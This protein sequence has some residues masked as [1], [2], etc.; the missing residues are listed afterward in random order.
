MIERLILLAV[1]SLLA[2]PSMAFLKKTASFGG[3]NLPITVV[4][5]SFSNSVF[6]SPTELPFEEAVWHLQATADQFLGADHR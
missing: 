5:T 1:L 4:I 6:Y 2:L 3:W